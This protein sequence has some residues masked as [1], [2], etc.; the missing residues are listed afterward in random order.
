[1]RE[2]IDN[3]VAAGD[4]GQSSEYIRDLMRRDREGQAQ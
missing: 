3:R 2:H 1:M 4:C